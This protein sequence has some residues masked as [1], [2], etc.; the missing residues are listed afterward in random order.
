M[1]KPELSSWQISPVVAHLAQICRLRSNQPDVGGGAGAIADAARLAAHN[2][3]AR[4]VGQLR[5]GWRELE[6]WQDAPEVKDV[7]DQLARYG[8]A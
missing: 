4:L 3:C 7:R 8:V 6:T 5:A 2:R 1:S